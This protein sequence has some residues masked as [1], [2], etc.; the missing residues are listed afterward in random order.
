MAGIIGILGQTGGHDLAD[1]LAQL[2]HRGRSLRTVMAVG[3]L[4]LGVVSDSEEDYFVQGTTAAAIDGRILNLMAKA[5]ATGIKGNNPAEI[6]LRLYRKTGPTGLRE[7]DGE[8][9]FVICDGKDV[10]LG[11]DR[12]GVKPLYYARTTTRQIIASELKA[13]SSGAT[14]VKYV[15]P[16]H[17]LILHSDQEFNL[18]H[19]TRPKPLRTGVR[20]SGVRLRKLLRRAIARRIDPKERIG[21]FLSGGIDSAAVALTALDLTSKLVCFTVGTRRS[22]DLEMAQE[23]AGFL[24]VESHSRCYNRAQMLAVL[25]KVI[26]HLESYDAPLV[27]SAI[28]NYLVAELT[29]RHGVRQVLIGEGGDELFAGYEDLKVLSGLRLHARLWQLLNSLHNSGLQRCDR[30]PQAF[31][32]QAVIPFLDHDLCRF[33]FGIDPSL[34][35]NHGVEKWI[36][37]K[38]F[39]GLLPGEIVWRRKEKFSA[40]AG[41]MFALEDAARRRYRTRELALVQRS[42][43]AAGVRTLEEL[44]YYRVFRSFFPNLSPKALLG[45]TALPLGAWGQR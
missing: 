3:N 29:E 7:L 2:S 11:R 17:G 28:P 30:M 43:P 27:R 33:A 38:A 8:F 6:L 1:G 23:L 40:G 25:P 9:A 13:I 14:D 15:R 37:R 32:L 41:S 19:E 16:G 12:L 20:A 24:K 39:E 36:L 44:L 18:A 42:D 34:K 26:Y 35:V 4:A 21:V 5:K 10:I 45:R 22:H 31:G